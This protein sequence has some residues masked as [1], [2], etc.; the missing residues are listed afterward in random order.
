MNY[1]R[2]LV[3]A[4]MGFIFAQIFVLLGL[5]VQIDN[6]KFQHLWLG[7]AIM[8]LSYYKMTQK[9]SELWTDFFWFGV[10]ITVNDLVIDPFNFS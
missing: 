7:I 2:M 3:V 1:F 10:G 8:L 9:K 4:L 5:R 6:M